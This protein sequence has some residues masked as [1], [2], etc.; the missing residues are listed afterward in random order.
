MN[1]AAEKSEKMAI[2]QRALN[3]FSIA[4][5]AGILIVGQDRIFETLRRGTAL[6]VFITDDCSAN[7]ARR[8]A[9]AQERGTADIYKLKDTGRELLGKSI[10]MGAAQAAALPKES[11]LAEKIIGLLS[12]D[13]SDADE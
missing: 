1:S 9:S 13:R 5:R 7:V 8:L 11:G 6:A 10:G 4:R 12:E 3:M 2:S